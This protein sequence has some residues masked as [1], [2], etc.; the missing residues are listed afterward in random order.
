M[1]FHWYGH[2]CFLLTTENGA[3]VLT[4]P[5]E[6]SIGYSLG[7]VEADIVTISHEHDDHNNA[8][9]VTG[10]PVIIKGA[11]VHEVKGVKITGIKATTIQRRARNAGKT[12]C[13]FLKRMIC[14]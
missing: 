11:G 10:N 14:A 4:D 12:P 3:R 8:A 2:S 1:L 9:A 13:L 6:N 5:F 7:E